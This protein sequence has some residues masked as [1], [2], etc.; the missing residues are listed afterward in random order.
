MTPMTDEELAALPAYKRFAI[1]E[2]GWLVALVVVGAIVAVVAVVAVNHTSTTQKHG[3]LDPTTQGARGG[4]FCNDLTSFHDYT[5][6]RNASRSRLRSVVRQDIV[7]LAAMEPDAPSDIK[8][9]IVNL[10]NEYAASAAG[11]VNSSNQQAWL[12]QVQQ[13]NKA[14]AAWLNAHC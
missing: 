12:S 4:Q 1:R 8:A 11:Q 5:S 10:H 2:L 9:T 6:H 14:L 3:R 7:R 13:D